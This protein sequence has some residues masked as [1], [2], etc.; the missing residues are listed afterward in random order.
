MD[1][2]EEFESA[3]EEDEKK[4]LSVEES[5]AA[6]SELEAVLSEPELVGAAVSQPFEMVEQEVPLPAQVP[7]P[8]VPEE[9]QEHPL[10][11]EA[12]LPVEDPVQAIAAEITQIDLPT[13]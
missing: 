6:L 8:E 9:V 13:C 10:S 2:E 4:P 11:E 7:V 5:A 3:D 12:D 1:S